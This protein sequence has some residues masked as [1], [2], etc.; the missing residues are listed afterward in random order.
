MDAS[1]LRQ[2][3]EI[4]VH[5]VDEILSQFEECFL[6]LERQG[7]TALPNE[8]VLRTARMLRGSS[9]ALGFT[10][11]ATFSQHLESFLS[12]LKT[13]KVGANADVMSLLWKSRDFIQAHVQCL[14]AGKK[15]PGEGE[16]LT[17]LMTRVSDPKSVALKI[18]L[19]R[20]P[21]AG[22]IWFVGDDLKAVLFEMPE[23]HTTDTET[24]TETADAHTAET[25]PSLSGI[26]ETHS[27]S[28]TRIST[29]AEQLDAK[30]L[31]IQA[32]I[33]RLTQLAARANITTIE[34]ALPAEPQ[35]SAVVHPAPQVTQQT[36]APQSVPEENGP[37][38]A[39]DSVPQENQQTTVIDSQTEVTLKEQTV[40]TVSDDAGL[41][42]SAE[43]SEQKNSA[44]MSKTAATAAT[45]LQDSSTYI[46]QTSQIRDAVTR[47][48]PST[49]TTPP[50]TTNN[51]GTAPLVAGTAALTD[52]HVRVSLAKVDKILNFVGELII[53]QSIFEEH[54]SE[55]DAPLLRK[56]I[57]QMAKILREAQDVTASLRLVKIKPL[58]AKMQRMSREA[59]QRLNKDIAVNLVGEDIE[60]DKI[61]L[62]NISES[63]VTLVRH[64]LENGVESSVER[65]KTGKPAQGNIWLK[66]S[67]LSKTV[68]IEIRD[69]GCGLDPQKIRAQAIQR[70]LIA[71]FEKLSDEK[72]QS[73]IFHP[74]FFA[75]HLSP[76]A[77]TPSL[78]LDAVKSKIEALQGFIDLESKAGEGSCFRI[79]LPLSV[80]VIDGFVVRLGRERFVV[81]KA[82]VSETV[83][84]HEAD[85]LSVHGQSEMLNLRGQTIPLFYLTQLLNKQTTLAHNR[86]TFDGIAL[87]VQEDSN[88]RF[89]VVVDDVISQQQIV[90]KRLGHELQSVNGLGGAAVLGDGKPA[91]ILDLQDLIHA[92]KGERQPHGGPPTSDKAA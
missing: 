28:T 56:S 63:L 68:V 78:G 5:E 14:R 7:T 54:S 83:R 33:T 39:I 27:I 41:L 24:L 44:E 86:T 71:P 76:L 29:E 4:F 45:S 85:V 73:L 9:A 61:L 11:L 32:A 35:E 69:D 30:L 42:A 43:T 88:R 6:D 49:N 52:D 23:N 91:V 22:D 75:R 19:P 26:T 16:A 70:G 34:A 64:A 46:E 80:A 37:T 31:A 17:E 47:I 48:R 36:P 40:R 59:A 13:N 20:P 53:L 74:G 21:T 66:A 58:F 90:V 81:S 55:T 77:D 51:T 25:S 57:T 1:E 50:A 92:P 8:K 82:Q 15:T 72:T 38:T 62:D 87:V 84:P 65:A 12:T 60:I 2:I 3:V 79:H 89:A 18:E 10:E 67:R